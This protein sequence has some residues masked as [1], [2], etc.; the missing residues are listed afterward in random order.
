[1]K[2]SKIL[3][4]ILALSV[5]IFMI[6]YGGMDDSPGAQMLGLLAIIVGTIFAT[7]KKKS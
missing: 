5:G 4:V 1:M 2:V 7:R 3:Y 6:V